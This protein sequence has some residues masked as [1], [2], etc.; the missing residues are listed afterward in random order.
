M[1]EVEEEVLVVVVV[2]RVV[3]VVMAGLEEDVV[4]V[5]VVVTTAE[6]DDGDGLADEELGTVL[7][8]ADELEVD[9]GELEGDGYGS[10]LSPAALELD[11]TSAAGDDVEA[12]SSTASTVEDDADDVELMASSMLEAGGVSICI[13]EVVSAINDVL[14]ISITTLELRAS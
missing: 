10:I 5:V 6:L 13:D 2:V 1:V 9:V 4:D 14:D 11:V 12:V 8:A 3:V 7:E